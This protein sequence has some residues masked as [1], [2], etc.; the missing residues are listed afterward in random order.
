[1]LKPGGVNIVVDVDDMMGG[2]LDPILPSLAYANMKFAA[3]VFAD[4]SLT[5]LRACNAHLLEPRGL[6]SSEVCCRCTPRAG[7]GR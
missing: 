1:M 7:T 6:H 5:F 3:E 4:S 2:V